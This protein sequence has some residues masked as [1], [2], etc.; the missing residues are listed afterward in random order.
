MIG[1]KRKYE[2]KGENLL[3]TESLELEMFMFIEEM[4]RWN[5]ACPKLGVRTDPCLKIVPQNGP[6]H[7]KKESKQIKMR[8]LINTGVLGGKE[9]FLS[10]I[11]N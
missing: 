4:K 9:V 10:E 11:E 5:W 8:K 7:H 3:L 2:A 6:D 1:L